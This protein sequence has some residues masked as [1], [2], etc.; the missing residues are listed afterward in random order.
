MAQI[1]QR[2]TAGGEPRWDVR[3]RVAGQVRTKT[4]TRRRDARQW[5]AA[6]E[7]SRARGGFVDPRLG[8]MRVAELL[9]RW[10]EATAPAK[11]ETTKVADDLAVRRWIVPTLGGFA[12]A[13]VTPGDVQAVVNAWSRRLAPRTVRRHYGVLRAALAF[14]VEADWLART[15]CRG[16]KL[17][18]VPPARR[19]RLSPADIERIALAM[20]ERHRA[21]VWLAVV[22]GMRWSEIAGLR[23]GRVDFGRGEI[24]VAE[25]IT[26]GA[27]G[28]LVAGPPKSEAG[29]RTVS[30]SQPVLAM[31]GAHL[32]ARG[33]SR[34]D[35]EA[36]VFATATG[37][38]LH[39]ST[40]RSK[41]WRPAVAA[42]GVDGAGFHD[43]RRAN[44]TALVLV[45]TD[46]TVAQYRLGH[47]DVRMTLDV[48]AQVT[49]E[50]HRAAAEALGARFLPGPP[51]QAPAPAPT[52]D[53]R[54]MGLRALP[55]AAG[56]QPT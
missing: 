54:A 9:R 22:T 8:R 44:A 46:V 45:G 31:V 55:Q 43:L 30:V 42:A 27:G 12:I 7:T 29:H 35:A 39:Y 41:V 50:A 37:A 48:Y 11:R 56:Q 24:E 10:S 1:T 49:D 26:R 3:V 14:A 40:W 34:D 13:E 4:F 18:A 47:A 15:P 19:T 38:P 51:E 6:V 2:T 52:R 21:V 36:L 32:A 28:R 33:V 23:V 20:P 17:P 25:V 53:A 16:V 5:A